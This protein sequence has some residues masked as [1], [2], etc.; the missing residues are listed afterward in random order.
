[1]QL[2]IDTDAEYLVALN[3]C[4]L[5]AGYYYLSQKYKIIPPTPSPPMN[6]PVHIECYLLK[7]IVS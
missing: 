6:A 5:V 4:S 1:M 2:Y 3:S 7:H